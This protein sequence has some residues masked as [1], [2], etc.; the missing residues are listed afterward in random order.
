MMTVSQ[1]A[2]RKA[3]AGDRVVLGAV[4]LVLRL[5]GSV[6]LALFFGAPAWIVASSG[7][8]GGAALAA[9]AALASA[10]SLLAWRNEVTLTIESRTY[11]WERGFW[12]FVRCQGG[13]LDEFDHLSLARQTRTTSGGMQYDVRVLRL[14]WKEGASRTG[15]GRVLRGALPAVGLGRGE[16][17]DAEAVALAHALA[18]RTGLPLRAAS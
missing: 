15:R 5:L 17:E 10:F 14:A 3:L 12:P 2:F 16:D 1:K 18:W 11:V 6:W 9:L 8:R 4:P 13:S 7:E